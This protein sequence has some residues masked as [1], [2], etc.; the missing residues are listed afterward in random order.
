[1]T[2]ARERL[3]VALSG[4]RAAAWAFVVGLTVR[5]LA[6][7]ALARF[8]F[9]GDE[10]SYSV[11]AAQLLDRAQFA[12]DWPPGLPY[13][14]TFAQSLLGRSQVVSMVAMVPWY[15]AF[16]AVLYALVT[17]IGG[18][19]A[20]NIALWAFAVYPTFVYHSVIPLTQLPVAVCVMLV[21][22]LLL[23]LRGRRSLWIPAVIGGALGSAVLMR[24]SAFL[25]ALGVPVF[26][27]VRWRS[28]RAALVALGVVAAL[29]V[30]WMAKVRT[31]TG[32]VI[33]INCATA[34]NLYLGNN[35][36]TPF[37]KTWWLGSHDE[38]G[39][40]PDAFIAEDAR[41]RALPPAKEDAEYRAL[42]AEH[43]RSRPG[44]FALR[45]LNRIR[46]YFAFDTY[47]GTVLIKFNGLPRALGLSVIAL[48]A[49]F[50]LALM[51]LSLT[52]FL[53]PRGLGTGRVTRATILW[54]VTAYAIPY[55]V[56]FSHPTYHIPVVPLLAIPGAVLLAQMSGMEPG[57]LRNA[58]G[59]L[60]RRRSVWIG[61]AAFA[62]VQ[63]EWVIVMG[64]GFL[65]KR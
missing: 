22:L 64:A 55:W 7:V 58:L 9:V 50:Y 36:W 13:Y 51:A 46:A 53:A 63:V 27:A 14:L 21:A 54:I 41:T 16:S 44:H 23:V 26:T 45:T 28:L 29:V 2:S 48:D 52:A 3:A 11:M 33:F 6:L 5:V 37:Y 34:R 62:A 32:D 1:M 43:V 24:P 12:P 60:R 49:L 4:R 42:A 8:P 31:M 59:T 61:L 25:L 15:V 20:A 47:A 39:A 57:A 10:R 40:V 18:R 38:P 35:E 56:A 17:R 30:P 65:G 19:R